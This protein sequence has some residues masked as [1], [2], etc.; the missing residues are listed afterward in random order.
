MVEA[1]SLIVRRNPNIPIARMVERQDHRPYRRYSRDPAYLN[2]IPLLGAVDFAGDRTIIIVPMLK[3]NTPVGGVG[4]FRQEVRPFTDKQV[5]LVQNFAAQ[6]VI[7]IENTRLLN[8]LRQRTDD[9]RI[10]SNK[11]RPR[12]CCVSSVASPGEI[13]PVFKAMLDNATRICEAKSELSISLKTTIS[14]R[15]IAA[16]WYRR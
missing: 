5:T 12:K 14:D 10:W 7:A 16:P 2:A 3:E 4:I 11:Q 1:G 8:E 9:L 15:S 6:A 13:E